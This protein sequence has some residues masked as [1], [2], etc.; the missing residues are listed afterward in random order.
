MKTAVVVVEKSDVEKSGT[1]TLRKHKKGWKKGEIKTKFADVSFVFS[2]WLAHPKNEVAKPKN[3]K[4]P[5]TFEKISYLCVYS[6]FS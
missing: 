6:L 5:V 1:E 4:L 2:F 3:V